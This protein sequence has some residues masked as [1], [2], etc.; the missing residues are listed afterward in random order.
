MSITNI[1]EKWRTKKTAIVF[2]GILTILAVALG[3]NGAFASTSNN[4]SWE[5]QASAPEDIQV[6]VM[7]D[8]QFTLGVSGIN[9]QNSRYAINEKASA[10]YSDSIFTIT[11]VS[12]GKTGIVFAA[13]NTARVTIVDYWIKDN[14][15]VS[16]YSLSD[17]AVRLG[18]NEAKNWK[19]LINLTA[20][21]GENKNATDAI[22][23]K[24]NNS[25]LL[26][27]ENGNIVGQGKDGIAVMSGAF[28]DVWGENQSISIAVAVGSLN[29][30]VN[31]TGLS[32][33]AIENVTTLTGGTIYAPEVLVTPSN[34]T[35][36]NIVWTSSNTYYANVE[37]FTGTV[38]GL[39]AGSV[40]IT[41]TVVNLDG[42]FAS[43]SYD[44]EILDG[45]VI[46]PITVS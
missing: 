23:W 24:S 22:T 40:T 15:N 5:A 19:N 10:V 27:Y 29:S 39:R 4:Q 13:K 26:R 38:S 3:V 28:T 17:N 37:A 43:V 45:C 6:K 14:A 30:I 7:Q 2:A 9:T 25:G 42:T 16:S 21:S 34:A 18:K 32:L 36:K 11:P 8:G 1:L 35:V 31:A 44:V 33:E 20:K 12:A 46:P 41:A